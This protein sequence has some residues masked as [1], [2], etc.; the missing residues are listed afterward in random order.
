MVTLFKAAV[1]VAVPAAA[2]EPTVA[3]KEALCAP[4][5]TVTEAGTETAASELVSCT[6]DPPAGAAP[7]RET[8]QAT[9]AGAVTEA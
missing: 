7:L 5:A 3:V 1:M 6:F 9:A 2:V 4:A 8:V